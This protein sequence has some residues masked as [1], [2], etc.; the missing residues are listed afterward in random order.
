MITLARKSF[1]LMMC[2]GQIGGLSSGRVETSSEYFHSNIVYAVREKCHKRTFTP[3]ALCTN[4]A[5][6]IGHQTFQ[7]LSSI[8]IL[9]LNGNLRKGMIVLSSIV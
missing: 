3:S 9:Y 6:R 7:F 2:T 8:R 4:L 1:A 5:H